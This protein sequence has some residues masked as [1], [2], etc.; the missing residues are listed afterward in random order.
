MV[1][2]LRREFELNTVLGI[3]YALSKGP[4]HGYEIMKRVREEFGFPKSPGVLYPA[5]RKLLS[6]GYIEVAE[7]IR[8]GGRYLRV[9]RITD[10]GVKVL[11]EHMN[12]VEELK[13]VARGFKIFDEVGGNRLKEAI[14]RVV[15]ILPSARREDIE[16]LRSAINSFV[17]FLESFRKKM[18]SRSE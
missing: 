11:S 3:L 13:R 8:R 2:P 9:Y 6:V 18:L 14:F 1:W 10:A 12:R 5:L 17:E 7:E 4:A 15:E 16:E